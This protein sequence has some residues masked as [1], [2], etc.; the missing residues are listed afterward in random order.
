MNFHRPTNQKNTTKIPFNSNSA[1][2]GVFIDD[3]NSYILYIIYTS[4]H[5]LV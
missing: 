4:L 3:E 5:Y 1:G 2:S